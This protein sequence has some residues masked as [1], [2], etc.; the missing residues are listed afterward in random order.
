MR[1]A[2]VAAGVDRPDRVRPL[3]PS[4]VV[5]VAGLPMVVLRRLRCEATVRAIDELLDLSDRLGVEGEQLS[6]AL[7]DVVGVVADRAVRGRLIALRR[8]VYQARAPRPGVLDDGVWA[9]LPADLAPRIAA[10]QQSL[11]QR[12]AL[13]ARAEATL[14]AECADKRLA[15]AA[16]AGD[17]WFQRGLVLASPDLYAELVKWLAAGPAARPDEALEAS[18]AKYVGRA[19]AKTTPYSTFTSLAEGHWTP[20]GPHPVRCAGAWT[21][22]S[23][24]EPAV[25]IALRLRREL[26][27]WPEITSHVRLRINPSVARDATTLRFLSPPGSVVRQGSGEAVVEVAVTPT[28]R[29][30]LEVIRAAP[31]PC[32]ASVAAAVAALDSTSGT[33]EVA[34]YLD[35]LVD[36]GL[37]EAQLDVA[38][39]SLDHLG[40]LSDALAGCTGPRV[41]AVRE[42]LDRLRAQLAGL[43]DGSR[44]QQRFESIGAVDATLHR[45]YTQLD[46][47]RQGSGV[48]GVPA[49]NAVFEDTVVTGLDYRFALPDWAGVLD[50]LRLLAG[51]SGLYDR[52]LA[53]RLALAAFFAGRYG[54]GSR[55]GFLE[56]CRAVRDEGRRPGAALGTILNQPWLAATAGLHT[57]DRIKQLRRQIAAQVRTAPVDQAGIRRLDR[58]ALSGFVAALPEFVQPRDS[59]AFY[60]QPMIRNGTASLVLNN[61]DAGFRRAHARLQ[62]FAARAHGDAHPTPGLPADSGVGY[63]DLAT[64]AGSNLNLR[65]SP[66]PYEITYPGSVSNRP[67]AEQISL[68]DLDVV[69]D[70]TTD[71]LRLVWRSR[72]ALVVPLHLGILVDWALPWTYRLLMQAFGVSSFCG[73]PQRLSG[74]SFLA[75]VQGVRRFP[76]L[77]LGN[78]VIARATWVV[79][80]GDAPLPEKSESTLS[81]LIRVTRWLAEHGIPRQSFVRAATAAG[82][83]IRVGKNRKPCYVDFSNQVFLRVFAQIA[84]QP[85]LMLVFQEV[86]PT[87]DDLLVTD[88]NAGYASE[89]VFEFDR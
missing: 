8:C 5:R 69:H 39:Q 50:D 79:G 70:E 77:C 23:A 37:L 52:N 32:Y 33:A 22:R 24:V 55:V 73:L 7:Y 29:R 48:P 74:L 83:P 20:A 30:V 12:D 71:R 51:L 13:R 26:A 84:A 47:T 65:L 46:W 62:R 2:L 14:E 89:C 35:H 1:P 19:A 42:L 16:A 87:D 53:P 49:K 18:L 9:V 21:R 63:A 75:P 80:P 41:D 86:L 58:R 61:T 36:V 57:L 17:D 56:W 28:L 45:L 64:I 25:R 78:V 3:V 34:A 85:D 40:G 88:G 81:H 66:A 68:G 31:D 43:A 15:L 38:D 6:Q 11:A 59:I 10:W 60:G 4:F 44:A 82:A 27:S 76:R 72:A 67:A 54:P